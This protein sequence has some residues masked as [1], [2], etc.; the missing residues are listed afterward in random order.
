MHAY[1][2]LLL[3]YSI[4]SKLRHNHPGVQGYAIT[5]VGQVLVSESKEAEREVIWLPLWTT[6]A[7]EMFRCTHPL[8]SLCPNLVADLPTAGK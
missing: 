1:P 7:L 2:P 4:L 5:E 3:E 8:L 6:V